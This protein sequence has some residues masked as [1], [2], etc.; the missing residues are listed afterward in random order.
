MGETG[1]QGKTLIR[2]LDDVG[3][4]SGIYSANGNYS[5]TPKAFKIVPGPDETFRISRVLISYL[6]A[7]EGGQAEYADSAALLTN[8]IIVRKMRD[9]VEVN[10]YTPQDN[11]KSN[12]AWTN[13]CFDMVQR[14]WNPPGGG[15]QI[16]L[17]WTFSKG[18][19]YIRLNGAKNEWL[20][21]YLSDDFTIVIDQ[22]FTIHGYD[23]K[24][25]S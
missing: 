15:S 12:G 7:T 8:G 14:T 6:F 21:F 19:Q 20:E 1:S 22:R 16:S 3:D 17:R 25:Q 18:G 9:G 2:Y 10:R 4:G 11:I 13:L 23:E 24:V 5:V